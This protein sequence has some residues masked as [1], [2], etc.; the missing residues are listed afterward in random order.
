MGAA[1]GPIAGVLV[2]AAITLE[3]V[4]VTSAST[5][6]A[7]A[8][9]D[10]GALAVAAETAFEVAASSCPASVWASAIVAWSNCWG[11]VGPGS[12]RAIA[13]I[14]RGTIATATTSRQRRTARAEIGA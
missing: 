1:G 3:T 12:E 2:A 14:A 8:R 4:F 7:L 6:A 5:L 13:G 9:T 10:A 11:V